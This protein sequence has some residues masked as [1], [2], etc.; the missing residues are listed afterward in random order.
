MTRV[1][2]RVQELAQAKGITTGKQLA[3]ATDLPF[4]TAYG[5]FNETI[6]RIDLRTLQTLCDALDCEVKDVLIHVEAVSGKPIKTKR[7]AK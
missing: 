4:A 1:Q 2:L 7:R 6:G 5:L 3:D